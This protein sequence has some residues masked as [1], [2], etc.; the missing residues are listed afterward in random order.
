MGN[1]LFLVSLMLVGSPLQN[2]DVSHSIVPHAVTPTTIYWVVGECHWLYMLEW[3]EVKACAHEV[4]DVEVAA[5][6]I[7]NDW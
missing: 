6:H 2:V 3:R 4:E 7:G 5:V 1:I